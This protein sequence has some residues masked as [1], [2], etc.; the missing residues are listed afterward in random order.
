MHNLRKTCDIHAGTFLTFLA[1]YDHTRHYVSMLYTGVVFG[2]KDVLPH[3]NEYCM[4]S[5]V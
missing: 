1:Q 4:R 5:R 2:G 3:A